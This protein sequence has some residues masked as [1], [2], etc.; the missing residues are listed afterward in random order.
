MT[1]KFIDLFC[2]IGGFHAALTALG[3]QCVMASDIDSD[4][5]R[6]YSDNWNIDPLGD[7]RS[8]SNER[9]VEVPNHDVLVG[10]FPCQPFSKSGFQRGMDEARGTLF[11]NIARI[12]EVKKPKIV[13]LEN[14]R[15]LV[16][17]RHIH[18]WDVIVNTL[19][20]FGY[21]ISSVPWIVSPHKIRKEFGGRPQVRDRVLI[22][23]T[24]LP[25]KWGEIGTDVK[26]PQ[27]KWA[28]NEEVEW[29]L[30]RDLPLQDEN[31]INNRGLYLSKEEKKWIR[32]WENLR[33]SIKS[34][35]GSLP[36]FPLWFDA[37][38][39]SGTTPLLR[40]NKSF[41]QWKNDFIKKNLE[42]Y[43]FH[44]SAIK[45]WF[46]ENSEILEFPASRRKFEW[47]A[48][49]AKSLSKCI[50]HFRPSG[51]R[52]K[53]PS[54]VPA[55]VAM[56]QT[57][58]L[59]SLQRRITVR[60]AARLQGFPDWFRFISQSDAISYK[61]LGNAIN[62]GVAYQSLKSQVIRDL[63]IL[64]A[65]SSNIV[66]AILMSPDNPDLILKNKTLLKTL[67]PE[68]LQGLQ[69]ELPLRIVN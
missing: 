34:D 28:Q 17:P 62:V 24:R 36:G 39:V 9:T 15:N 67:K 43:F 13:L 14:V 61:Q 11:W 54:Y 47:Q 66:K 51:I 60:E 64:L 38:P 29:Q 44:E 32:A 8:F 27:L 48:Q 41:P 65:D 53:K 50:L 20:N 58:I 10:G 40:P 49:D 46:R 55:L 35:G 68:S 16:G 4:A 57:T 22:A 1:F 23:A 30:E 18:E 2:G 25:E 59:G 5:R 19:Q 6:V 21:R 12:I 52:A 56:N 7:I 26:P 37:W 3:G 42:F 31:E 69:S 63:D 33:K 45:S